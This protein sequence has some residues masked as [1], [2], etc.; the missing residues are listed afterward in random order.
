MKNPAETAMI[1]PHFFV[2]CCMNAWGK[3]WGLLL[4][5]KTYSNKQRA[6]MIKKHPTKPVRI[7]IRTIACIRRYNKA[8]EG[9][10]LSAMCRQ[11]ALKICAMGLGFVWPSAEETVHVNHFSFCSGYWYLAISTSSSV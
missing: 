3:K 10:M 8:R 2:G 6:W 7:S 9:G 11:H 5:P 1:W 4:S